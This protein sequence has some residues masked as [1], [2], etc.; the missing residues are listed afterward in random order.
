V[1]FSIEKCIANLHSFTSRNE[2]AIRSLMEGLVLSGIAMSFV[3]NSRPASGSEHH[4]SHYCELMFLQMGKA[5]VLHGIKVG[6]ATVATHRIAELL[7]AKEMDFDCAGRNAPHFDVSQWEEKVNRLFQKAA[8]G[9]LK[10]SR[11]NN[12]NSI[13]ERVKRIQAVRRNWPKV[14]AVLQEKPS[15]EEIGNILKTVGAPVTPGEIGVDSDMVYNSIIYAKE[16]RNRYTVLQLVWDLGLSEECA[17]A[18]C[19]YYAGMA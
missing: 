18:I 3:G 19:D 4:I 5:P 12:R 2:F 15:A 11:E 8:P 10:Q 16:I 14:I 6:I 1:R 7:T 9:I 13:E 17:A